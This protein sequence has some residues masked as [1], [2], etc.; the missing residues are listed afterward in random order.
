MIKVV[1]LVMCL[2]LVG[3]ST[4]AQSAAPQTTA[5][6]TSGGNC[7]TTVFRS[8][9]IAAI[10]GSLGIDYFSLQSS[11]SIVVNGQEMDASAYN[12]TPNDFVV[13]ANRPNKCNGT[14][15][16][17]R[18]VSFAHG[19]EY[20]VSGFQTPITTEQYRF[21][22]AQTC[23]DVRWYDFHLHFSGDITTGGCNF[24]TF[25]K[26]SK[27][28]G[29]TVCSS[30]STV[31]KAYEEEQISSDIKWISVVSTSKGDSLCGQ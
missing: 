17:A 9:G 31:Q 2:F 14:Y 19:Y 25:V 20:E 10:L 7:S 13:L 18:R 26:V 6:A 1:S 12:P 30:Y 11:I 4:T 27:S 23:E 22:L 16:S 15:V 29:M 8:E 5:S 24:P 28:D 21:A 3:C